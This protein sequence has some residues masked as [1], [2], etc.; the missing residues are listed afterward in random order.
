MNRAE[1]GEYAATCPPVTRE[2]YRSIRDTESN[3]SINFAQELALS[4]AKELNDTASKST[5]AFV[6][7]TTV[8]LFMVF[9]DEWNAK[10]SQS[11]QYKFIAHPTRALWIRLMSKLLGLNSANILKWE[12]EK[13]GAYAQAGNGIL[14]AGLHWLLVE[15]E[16]E[17]VRK[18]RG[19]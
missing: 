9:A 10:K 17:G 3:V 5:S 4:F 16:S 19:F 18:A 13:D 2:V 6:L 11:W 8:E 15:F 14:L 1:V 7:D 12:K